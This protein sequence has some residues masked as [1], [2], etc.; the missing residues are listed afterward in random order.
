ML[1]NFQL[2]GQALLQ[3]FLLGQPE[4]RDTLRSSP[5]LEQLRQRVIAT[6]HLDPMMENE[7]EPYIVHRLSLVG[8]SG[9]PKFTPDAFQ[10]IYKATDGVPRRI[11][12]LASRVMLLGAIDKLGTIDAAVVEAVTADMAHDEEPREQ[13]PGNVRI[14][15]GRTAEPADVS[16][17][18]SEPWNAPSQPEPINPGTISPAFQ[19]LKKEV[20]Q[21]R[22]AFDGPRFAAKDDAA[23]PR[24]GEA[25]DRVAA[26]EARLDEQEKA[27]RRMLKLLVDWVERDEKDIAW[28]RGSKAA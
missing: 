19:T 6:H 4:F 22:D 21:L 5:A 8:W 16:E 1:S 9:N 13:A 15:S 10:A 28:L 14:H 11:N 26:V 25:L 24:L 3:I 23:D 2:G 20:E 7:T 17:E 27:I 12:A 18:I